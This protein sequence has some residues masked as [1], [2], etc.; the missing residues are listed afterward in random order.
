MHKKVFVPGQRLLRR[1]LQMKY[2]FIFMVFYSS[3][4]HYPVKL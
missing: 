2:E 3:D 4:V 1:L